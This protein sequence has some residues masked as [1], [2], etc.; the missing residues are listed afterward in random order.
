[1][2]SACARCA[3]AVGKREGCR[4]ATLGRLI[5]TYAPGV[6]DYLHCVVC[7]VDVSK[8][9]SVTMAMIE[10]V[11]LIAAAGLMY[12]PPRKHGEG[13]RPLTQGNSLPPTQHLYVAHRCFARAI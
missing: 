7:D 13:M 11:M 2:A 4:A 8:A 12:G 9:R 5:A 1:M 3:R 10:L 6:V